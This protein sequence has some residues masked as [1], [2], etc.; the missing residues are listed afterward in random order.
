M[1]RR[2]L[3]DS[4]VFILREQLEELKK[5]DEAKGTELLAALDEMEEFEKLKD[6]KKVSE[7]AKEIFR[8]WGWWRS[9]L[10]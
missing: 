8:S 1:P 7:K 10:R 3:V 2:E 9:E 5:T 4:T 6:R